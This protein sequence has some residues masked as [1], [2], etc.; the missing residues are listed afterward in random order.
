M[1]KIRRWSEMAGLGGP[2][3]GKI[4]QLERN[5]DVVTVVFKK[6][7]P[8]FEDLFGRECDAPVVSTSRRKNR[9]KPRTENPAVR[10]DPTNTFG[11]MTKS[12]NGSVR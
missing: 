6:F 2:F 10:N 4:K 3:V 12:Q 8:I 7:V 5:F 1:T 11:I 9:S